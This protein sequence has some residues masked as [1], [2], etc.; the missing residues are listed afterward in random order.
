[1]ANLRNETYND[2]ELLHVIA[3]AA[4]HDGVAL[5]ND[6]AEILGIGPSKGRS[7]GG[8]VST[9]LSWMRRN[10]LI[11]KV[12]PKNL[13][14]DSGTGWVITAFGQEVMQGRVNKAVLDA[15][16]RGAGTQVLIMRELAQHAYVHTRSEVATVVRREWQ[17]NAAQRR[18]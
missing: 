18:R 2:L 3:D 16:S 4:N 11:E 9:R 8:R 10:K 14:K 17:H 12:D 7:P 6:I 5:S 13:P 15:M 1:M